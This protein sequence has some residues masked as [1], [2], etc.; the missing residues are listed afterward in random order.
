MSNVQRLSARNHFRLTYQV[1]REV[2][3]ESWRVYNHLVTPR[4][5]YRIATGALKRGPTP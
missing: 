4:D 5:I 3:L 2:S 1:A